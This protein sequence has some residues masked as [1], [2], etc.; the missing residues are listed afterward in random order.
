MDWAI[1]RQCNLRCAHCRGIPAEEIFTAR[2]LTLLRGIAELRPGCL[3]VEGGE[4]LL[5]KNLFAI[6][7]YGRSL[8]LTIFLIANGMLVTDRVVRTLNRLG[9]RVMV[10]L[11]SPDLDTF[12]LIREGADFSTV[13]TAAVFFDEP[14]FRTA[15]HVWGCDYQR[16]DGGS[17][18]TIGQEPGCI[19]GKYM[20][21]SPNGDVWPC[22]FSPLLVGNVKDELIARIWERM[23]ESHFI[24]RMR[25]P[26]SRKGAC[27]RCPYG[28]ECGGCRARAFNLVKDWFAA[29]P[30]CPIKQSCPSVGHP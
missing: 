5:R 16:S 18:I 29:D 25:D 6:L 9:A 1:T 19:F 14:F 20:F 10:S 4:P 7:R 26:A 23:H 24:Q 28:A 3:I 8:G 17:A 21:I 30:A 15:A 12:E 13:V 27:G 11:D 22:S 2:A